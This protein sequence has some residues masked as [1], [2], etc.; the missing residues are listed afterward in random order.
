VADTL[1]RPPVAAPV[2]EPAYAERVKAPSGSLVSSREAGEAAGEGSVSAVA[3]ASEGSSPV[4]VSAQH[5][6]TEQSKCRETHKMRGSLSLKV[7]AVEVDGVQLLCDVSLG[8]P[9]PIVPGPLRRAVFE[10]VHGLAHPGIR[11]SRR[12]VAAR[13]VWRGLRSDVASWCRDCVVCSTAKVTQQPK[14]PVHKIPVPQQRFQHIHVDIVGP[15]PVSKRGHSYLLTVIDRSTRWLEAVPLASISAEEC[16]AA[17]VES[18]ISR[19]GVPAVITSDRG[20]QFTSALWSSLCS[21]LGTEHIMTTSYHP[22]S[23]GMV[24]RAHRQLKDALRAR[25]VGV[26]WMEHLPW[27][28]LGLRAA[29]KEDSA[30]CSAELVYGAAPR[31][32]KELFTGQQ[33]VSR[34]FL[35]RLNSRQPPEVRPRSFAE[36]VS[37]GPTPA[38]LN[39]R[40]VFVR[41]GG[42]VPPLGPVYEGPYLVLSRGLKTFSLDIG[43]RPEVVSVDRL[44][45]FLGGDQVTP[46]APPRRGRPPGSRVASEDS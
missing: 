11:A 15:L 8:K 42:I 44:K 2:S 35:E 45:P 18:W 16:A 46:A 7:E 37:L 28:L 21:V 24:E 32:P 38:L 17:L 22:Q 4:A 5:I 13:Y 14:A 30:V 23:N 31:L 20:R 9:R 25:L 3:A 10:A 34:E 12:M 27:V 39:A 41:K 1:S 19:F 29:P 33:E 40:F 6:A 26:N 43:G 36:A